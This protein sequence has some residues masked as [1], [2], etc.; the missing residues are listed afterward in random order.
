[1][2]RSFA[3]RKDDYTLK[4]SI[5]RQRLTKKEIE[6]IRMQFENGQK[7][8]MDTPKIVPMKSST[9]V[10]VAFPAATAASTSTQSVSKTLNDT[11]E[12]EKPTPHYK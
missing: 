9:P 2:L 6:D 10:L 7:T 1:M 12:P 11:K 5:K 3:P 4:K 8:K